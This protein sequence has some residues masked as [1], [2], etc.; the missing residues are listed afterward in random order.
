MCRLL[1]V[2]IGQGAWLVTV[3]AAQRIWHGR[4]PRPQSGAYCTRPQSQHGYVVGQF[5]FGSSGELGEG[6]PEAS[7]T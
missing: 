4:E 5:G 7:V 2:A 6:E 1:C 3:A